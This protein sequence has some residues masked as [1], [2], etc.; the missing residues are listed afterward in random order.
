MDAVDDEEEKESQKECKFKAIFLLVY[1]TFFLLLVFPQVGL[2]VYFYLT[3]SRDPDLLN[4][5]QALVYTHTNCCRIEDSFRDCVT[6][7]KETLCKFVVSFPVLHLNETSDDGDED[8]SAV[9]ENGCPIYANTTFLTLVT[10]NEYSMIATSTYYKYA[11]FDNVTFGNIT[12]YTNIDE[13]QVSIIP[14]SNLYNSYFLATIAM[15]V[16]MSAFCIAIIVA[17]LIVPCINT[18]RDGPRRSRIV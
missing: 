4:D 15:G 12:C 10:S 6:S 9:V 2:F 17:W 16:L 11:T 1:T 7:Q 13:S 14:F 18:K 3:Y 5:P 8:E